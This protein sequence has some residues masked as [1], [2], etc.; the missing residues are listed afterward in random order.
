MEV[1]SYIFD[2]GARMNGNRVAVLN[3][4]I[5]SHDT[6]NAG[7]PVIQV[8]ICK[9]NQNGI[10]AHFTPDQDRVASEKLQ[11]LHGV[12]GERDNGVVIIY[13]IRDTCSKASQYLSTNPKLKKISH[14]CW[15][16]ELTSKS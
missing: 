11:G 16:A 12:I 3:T 15:L 4:E 7:T 8:I 10:L 6:V 1:R 9:N 5:M 14:E 2:I 13:G